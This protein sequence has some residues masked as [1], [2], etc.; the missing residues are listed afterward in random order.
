[1]CRI[2]Q[3]VYKMLLE[4]CIKINFL[5]ILS[6]GSIII[7]FKQEN[8]SEHFSMS[9]QDFCIFKYLNSYSV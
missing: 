6:L 8:Y 9:R 7:D 2:I 5:F 4:N 1:M 3:E